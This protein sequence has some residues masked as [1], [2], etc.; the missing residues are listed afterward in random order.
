MIEEKDWREK[1]RE[2]LAARVKKGSHL[3]I[4]SRDITEGDV[5]IA[6]KGAK[7]D[8]M[9]FVPVAAAKG[10]RA[11]LSEKREDIAAPSQVER[12][13]VE[14]L[15]E[16]LGWVASD[17]YG[18]PSASLF[19]VAITGTN[20]KTSVSHWCTALLTK[21]GMPCAAI[22]TIGTFFEGAAVKA[23][24]LTTPDAASVQGLFYDIK[25]AGA[26]A[27]AIEASSIGLVQ[28]RLAGTTVDTAVFTNLT[29]DHLD[30]HKTE[31]AYAE[32]KALLFAFPGLKRAVLNLDDAFGRELA[33]RTVKA[34]IETVGYGVEG[35]TDTREVSEKV[36]RLFARNV[37][38]EASGMAFDVS[39]EGK[40][41]T[42]R[43]KVLGLFNVYNLLAVAAVALGAGFPA[44]VVFKEIA[45]LQPPAGRL[46][47]YTR[48]GM[49]LAVVDYCHTPDAI[50]KALTALRPTAA[51]RGGKLWIVFGAG[52]D[53][54]HGKRPVMGEVAERLSDVAIV[55][56]DNPRTEVPEAIAEAICAGFKGKKPQVILDRREAIVET[57]CRAAPE[58]VLLIAGKGHEDYQEVSGV[59]H[60][61]S[62]IETAREAANE[63]FVRERKEECK[64]L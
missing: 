54:D 43:A 61:F 24:A 5:F 14:N 42:V 11:V 17:F 39:W 56:N 60:H 30:Y 41:Y 28:G 9:R 44:E 63:R 23:P 19:G 50:E 52:G 45:V 53:R 47:V 58:D 18:N 49:P 51:K 62:D 57:F 34:G 13:E 38:S 21:L 20:G 7:V 37:H 31:Q 36:H 15:R 46:Q 1:T 12:L 33:L 26:K 40:N 55:T 29:R 64:T 22:G 16:R 25:E 8:A 35:E 3:R 2:W 10:A 6:L 59:K 27:F 4:D 48:P 32:A